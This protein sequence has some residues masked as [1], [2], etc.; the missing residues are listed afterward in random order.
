MGEKNTSWESDSQLAGQEILW[1]YVT[2]KLNGMLQEFAL[3]IT[4][5]RMNPAS[6]H[7]HDVIL[8]NIYIN[9]IV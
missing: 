4:L 7:L 8:V 2:L 1:I 6:P 5:I 9:I 3:V